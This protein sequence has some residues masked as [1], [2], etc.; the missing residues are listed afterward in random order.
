VVVPP[1]TYWSAVQE[2]LRRYDILLIDDEV[3]TGFVRTGNDFGATTLNIR[4]DMMTLAK[5]LTA[6]Y[7]PLSAAVIRGDMYERLRSASEKV[8]IFGHGYT[9]SGHP[10]S[11]A[12]ALKALEIYE[13]DRLFE[14]AAKVGSYLQERLRRFEA[15]PIIGEVRG[16]GLIAALE[17]VA[18]KSTRRPFT[19]VDMALYLQRRAQDHGLLVRAL[20]GTSVAICP[21]LIV[22][23]RQIDELVESLEAAV[24]ET[25]AYAKR[26]GERRSA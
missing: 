5:A 26:H 22:T 3:I 1:R 2:V 16:V 7:A 4:P 23:E 8:G 9:Y 19:G 25:Y 6:G 14:Q 15:H 20:G 13:R 24:D 12:V 11:C 18:S 10:V 21:P 17:L